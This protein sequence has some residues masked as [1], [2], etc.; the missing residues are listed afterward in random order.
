MARKVLIYELILIANIVS[1]CQ[2]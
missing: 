1:Y 2:I